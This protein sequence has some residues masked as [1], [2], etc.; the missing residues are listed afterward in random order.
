[1]DV[2][3]FISLRVT[4][5]WHVSPSSAAIFQLSVSFICPN[6]GFRLMPINVLP[7]IPTALSK[8]LCGP[9]SIGNLQGTAKS[10][11][12]SDSDLQLLIQY[13]VIRIVYCV[14]T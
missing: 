11:Y 1:M 10:G 8:N 6:I 5:T 4:G 2:S 7:I 3:H 9:M 12:A 13:S 14:K